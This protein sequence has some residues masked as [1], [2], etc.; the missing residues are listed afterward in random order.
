MQGKA[1]LA[2]FTITPE[3]EGYREQ[4]SKE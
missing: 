1:L 2:S 4:S 3:P